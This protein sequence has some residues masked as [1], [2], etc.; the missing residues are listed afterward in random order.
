MYSYEFSH[1]LFQRDHPELWVGI[2]RNRPVGVV[3]DKRFVKSP[4]MICYNP[5][6]GLPFVPEEYLLSDLGEIL[7]R[8]NESFKEKVAQQQEENEILR[9]RLREYEAEL[10]SLQAQFIA[11][12]G[13]LTAS[14]NQ[15]RSKGGYGKY[16]RCVVYCL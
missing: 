5:V 13:S 8:R 14:R 7:Y 1:E 16:G 12:F 2:Q 15:T 11:K 9:K 10:V 3:K 6:F 4:T